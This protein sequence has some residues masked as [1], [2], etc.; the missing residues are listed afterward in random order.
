[1]PPSPVV[2]A[3]DFSPASLTALDWAAERLAPS[4]LVAVHAVDVPEPPAFLAPLLAPVAPVR[5]AAVDGARARLDAIARSRQGVEGLVRVGRAAAVVLEV[6]RERR[7]SSIVVGPHGARAGLGR[8]IG[9]T[10][11]RVARESPCP[12]VVARD[13]A[14]RPVRRILVAVD[15]STS[16]RAALRWAA[17]FASAPDQE[18]HVLH[19]V[20]P[21]LAGAVGIAATGRERRVAQ[22]GLRR[23]AES[24][25]AAEVASAGL[26]PER[27]ETQ[28]R[29]GDPFAEIL[30][31][32][33]ALD[34]DVLVVGRGRPGIL[35]A[36]GSVADALIRNAPAVT[37]VTP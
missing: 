8:L 31:A 3:L 18:L 10:A 13:T 6:A 35:G 33:C 23:A 21:A 30:A 34:A 26:P 37:V 36:I 5:E 24:W 14:G 12:V 28:V 11:E 15:D 7:A 2:V 9:S 1:M 20:E 17:S 4:P 22:E 29:F 32:A 27:T 16:G 19:V 25:V